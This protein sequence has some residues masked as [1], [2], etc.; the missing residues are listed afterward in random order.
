M[1][2]TVSKVRTQ[3]RF[4]FRVRMKRSAQPLPSGARTK[5][6]ELS[7]PRKA[8]SF[9]KPSDMYWLPWSWRTDRPRAASFA[10][11]PKWR[12]TP[13]RIGSSASKRVARTAAWI[14][15]HDEHGG[16]SLAGPVGGPHF[17]YPV[18]EYGAGVIAWPPRRADARGREQPVFAHQPQDTALGGAHPGD[19]QPSP[20]L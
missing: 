20:D 4:S 19:A 10:N 11:A 1:S 18:R 8:S 2:S 7:M 13:W 15:T 12:R 6:G 9:W 17:V 3:S 16:L 14:P 5:A